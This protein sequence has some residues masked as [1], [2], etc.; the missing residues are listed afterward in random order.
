M[1]IITYI[2]IGNTYNLL[3]L[4]TISCMYM[5]LGLTTWCCITSWCANPWGRPF[6]PSWSSKL[7]AV[8]CLGVECLEKA[9][10]MLA[11]QLVLSLFQ[12]CLDSHT[13]VASLLFLVDTNS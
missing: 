5:I 13:V 4:F 3:L 10:S 8:L 6:L 2:C 12:S 11:C 7:P 1:I 9:A